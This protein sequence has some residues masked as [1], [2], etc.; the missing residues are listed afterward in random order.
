VATSTLQTL[1]DNLAWLMQNS[2]EYG[3]A[4]LLG[5]KAGVDQKTIW[6]ILNHTNQ[7][8]IDKLAKLAAVFK[9]EAW[10]LLAP[11]LGGELYKIDPQRRIVPVQ[12]V[13]PPPGFKAPAPKTDE[14]GDAARP[15]PAPGK[16]PRLAA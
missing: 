4:G 3:S 9:L 2:A 5:K 7:P 6:R 15:E 10:Q 11:R 16:R 13:A 1:A 8:T 14:A 12:E